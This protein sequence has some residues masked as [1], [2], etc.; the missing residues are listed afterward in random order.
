MKMGSIYSASDKALFDAINNA[1]VTTSDLRLLFLKHGIV[2]SSK[3]PRKTLAEHYSRL[4]HDF[5]DFQSL[6]K[7]FDSGKRRERSSSFMINNG[8]PIS[9]YENAA[10]E[11]V[12]E[13]KKNTDSAMLIKQM[14]GSIKI[15]IRYKV[16]NF[17]KSEFKQVEVK[18]ATITIE[19]NSAGV[20][21]RGPQ[22]DKVDE[23]CRQL[24]SAVSDK[25]DFVL[26]IDEIS[27]ENNT[28]A[29]QRTK[30]FV[31]LIDNLPGY[32]KHTVTDVYVY[33]P[34]LD[35]AS[36]KD[37]IEDEP[38]D[39]DPDLGIHITKASLKGQGV[40]ESKEFSSLIEN[41][42]FYISKIVWQSKP[43]GVD[44]DIYEFEAQFSEPETC[45]KFS[46]LVRGV[47]K[48][49]NL[50]EHSKSRQHLDADD[51]LELNKVIE[52]SA[53]K[54]INKLTS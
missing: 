53:R 15:Q 47:Y 31:N 27:L 13:L 32:P 39:E 29:N 36:N 16:Y 46:Y 22:N 11:V 24:I 28:N 51:E 30:F 40:L 19:E 23:V 7:L 25:I 14:D 49:L 44:S 12:E 21:V 54:S 5:N 26:K 34:K 2:I 9:E 17:N 41:P 38:L 35:A 6:A 8:P 4:I 20:L 3:T 1:S 52:A 50:E 10:H 37:D 48:Y 18:T 33:K 43:N 42:E 45:T